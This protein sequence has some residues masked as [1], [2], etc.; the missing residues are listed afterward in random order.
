MVCTMGMD[1]VSLQMV[2]QRMKETSKKEYYLVAARWCG[3]MEAGTKESGGMEKCTVLAEK[4]APMEVLDM[5]ESGMLESVS[6]KIEGDVIK[7][8]VFLQL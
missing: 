1:G 6:G 7:C 3:A 5:K 8:I 2:Q 4:S